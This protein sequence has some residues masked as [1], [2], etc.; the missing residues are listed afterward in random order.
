MKKHKTSCIVTGTLGLLRASTL[1]AKMI[2]DPKHM[3]YESCKNVRITSIIYYVNFKTVQVLDDLKKKKGDSSLPFDA[4]GCS[5]ENSSLRLRICRL[6][7]L[8]LIRADL[9]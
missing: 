8:V 2:C 1:F 7:P 6:F 5:T 4:P 3:R 9:R